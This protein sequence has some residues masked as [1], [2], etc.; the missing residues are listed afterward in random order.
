MFIILFAVIFTLLPVS[1]DSTWRHF[2]MPAI[3]LGASSV[4]AVMRLTRT[5]LLEVMGSD[6]IRTARAKGFNMRQLL[7]RHALRNAILPVIS[8]LAVQLG[9]KLGGSVI[10]ESVF[11]ING[12]GRLALEFDHRRRRA[13]RADAGLR[14]HADLRRAHLPRRRA[15]RVARPAHA[16]GLRRGRWRRHTTR[17]PARRKAAPTPGQLLRRRILRHRGFVDGAA[18]IGVM[19]VLAILAPLMAPHDP[20]IQS[21]SNRMLPPVWS[22]EGLWTYL[23][24]T[25]H[26]GRDYLSRLLYGARI[27]LMIGLGAASIGCVIGVTLGICAGYFGGRVDPV[28]SY[29]LT[30]QLA[31]PGLLSDHVAGVPDR[32]VAARGHRR[33]RRDALELLSRGQ[34]RGGDADTRARL[35]RRR[36]GD[37]QQPAPGP[38]LRSAAEP[39]EPDH[40]HLHAGN[41]RRDPGRGGALLPRRRPA[42][43]DARPGA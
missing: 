27:S 21:L 12:L 43:A 31:M 29:L 22:D 5:G 6:Y 19:L 1:G 26:L 14:L 41:R 37:G 4:P 24:G 8:V 2:V 10:I 40:R 36:A 20:Y 33:H 25:D 7:L 38:V 42:A 30:C 9:H 13:D 15:Q 35:H 18:I 32:P 3:V 16:A 17:H 23:L 39:A 34:P 11:A 28:I